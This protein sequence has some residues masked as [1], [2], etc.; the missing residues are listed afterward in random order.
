MSNLI[1]A[2]NA[3]INTAD[4]ADNKDENYK[5]K[6]FRAV[7]AIGEDGECFIMSSTEDCKD[8]DLLPNGNIADD[9]GIEFLDKL[10]SGVYE[11]ELS[12][13]K[14]NSPYGDPCDIWITAKKINT[15]FP[16]HDPISYFSC[17]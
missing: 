12:I 8:V 3:A 2:E 9:N 1:K 4:I 7:I 11:F 14:D 6:D 17:A 10:I 15:L 16:S 13:N 5:P